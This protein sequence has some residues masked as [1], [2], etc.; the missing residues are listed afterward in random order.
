MATKLQGLK[1]WFCFG[2]WWPLIIGSSASLHSSLAR[3]IYF[4]CWQELSTFFFCPLLDSLPPPFLP[5]H[6][7][8]KQTNKKTVASRGCLF[9][10]LWWKWQSRL[11][12]EDPGSPCPS[13]RW[14]W[15][16]RGR[17]WPQDKERDEARSTEKWEG[18][19]WWAGGDRCRKTLGVDSLEAHRN[20]RQ[21]GG[22]SICH[23]RIFRDSGTSVLI[24]CA[25]CFPPSSSLIEKHCHLE[26]WRTFGALENSS[27]ENPSCLLGPLVGPAIQRMGKGRQGLISLALSKSV[28][29]M[30][31]ATDHIWLFKWT[32]TK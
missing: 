12:K 29:P 4:I 3:I 30:T 1:I 23:P 5:F 27:K 31:V 16:R 6:P 21:Q 15:S 26:V 19:S 18:A 22:F 20:T 24:C 10:W 25:L 11:G 2:L 13:W 32:K 28:L 14:L 7:S 8:G 17:L 9:S